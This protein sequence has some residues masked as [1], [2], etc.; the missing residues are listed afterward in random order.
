MASTTSTATTPAQTSP[1][2]HDEASLPHHI[3]PGSNATTSQSTEA[4]VSIQDGRRN[5]LGEP[6][7]SSVET[8]K[9]NLVRNQ[10]WNHQDLKRLHVE[11]GLKKEEWNNDE[12]VAGLGYSYEDGENRKM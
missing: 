8:W 5:S 6:L 4:D 1:T 11:A 9:P 7:Q 3:K 2:H 12:G 10:S